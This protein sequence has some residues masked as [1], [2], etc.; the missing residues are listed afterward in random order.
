MKVCEVKKAVKGWV[1]AF[2]APRPGF[3]G[4]H[5]GGSICSVP[6]DE[7]FPDTSDVDVHVIIDGPVPDSFVEVTHEMRQQKVL[8]KGAVIDLSYGEEVL[9]SPMAAPGM[10]WSDGYASDAPVHTGS[11]CTR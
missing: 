4:A 8:S 1:D 3:A 11:R 7:P 9:R 6:G 5:L 10:R 2:Q